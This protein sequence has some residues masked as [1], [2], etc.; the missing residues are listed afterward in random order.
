M[1]PASP[2]VDLLAMHPPEAFRARMFVALRR[3]TVII[4]ALVLVVASLALTSCSPA[5]GGIHGAG[6]ARSNRGGSR[7]VLEKPPASFGV[8]LGIVTWVDSQ[9]STE[10]FYEGTTEPGRKLEVEILYPTLSVKA[11]AVKVMA[12]PAYRFGPYPVVVFAHGYNVDPNTYRALLVSWVAAGY[13][14]VAPFFPDTSMSAVAAQH[15]VD[16]EGDIFNQPGDVAFIV[17]QLVKAAAGSQLVR[18]GYLDK[19]IDPHRLIL[20]GQS[21]GGDTVAALMYDH[22]YAATRRALAVKPVA[23]ALLS[24]DE[25]LRAEDVY[26][27][28]QGPGPLVLVVQSLTDSCNDP[29]NSSQLYDMLQGARKW[30][31]A[32]DNATHLGPYV[33]IGAGSPVVQQVTT[34]FFNLAVGRPKASPSALHLAGDNPGVS[35]ITTTASVPYYPAPSSVPDACAPP[36]G[37]PTD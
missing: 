3:P 36:A 22:A 32:L 31:L 34:A 2:P 19:M 27:P 10:N 14:V 21:D 7:R 29:S 28:P 4:G 5:A 8:G 23:V 35:S 11:P 30:F 6:A 13:V 17:S 24:A 37:A 1:A 18:I 33:G 20:A 26:S 15:G 16:T 9:G 25:M 12:A